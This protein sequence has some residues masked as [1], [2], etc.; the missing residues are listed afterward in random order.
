MPKV[1][2]INFST[3]YDLAFFFDCPECGAHF[4][5]RI[6]ICPECGFKVPPMAMK[7]ANRFRIK[8]KKKVK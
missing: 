8:P 6:S 4:S 5:N 3:A 7:K 2:H 1:A